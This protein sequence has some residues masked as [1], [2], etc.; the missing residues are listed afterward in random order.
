MSP[1]HPTLMT[2]LVLELKRL[3]CPDAF[4]D[5]RL[6]LGCHPLAIENRLREERHDLTAITACFQRKDD[7]TRRGVQLVNAQIIQTGAKGVT[8]VINVMYFRISRA[9]DLHFTSSPGTA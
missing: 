4:A 3:E 7:P 5:V 1:L 8:N 9:T 2:T 6:A